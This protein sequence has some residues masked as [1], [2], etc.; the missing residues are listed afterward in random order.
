MM[1]FLQKLFKRKE[2]NSVTTNK[3]VSMT[4]STPNKPVSK[5]TPTPINRVNPNEEF[6]REEKAAM[7]TADFSEAVQLLHILYKNKMSSP[8]GISLNYLEGKKDACF[9]IKQFI[10]ESDG[11]SLNDLAPF[12]RSMDHSQNYIHED[13][14]RAKLEVL[15]WAYERIKSM[16][17]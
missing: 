13:F 10:N 2:V 9:Y 3:T 17:Y 12:Q 6:Y 7:G 15:R 16:G 14:H 11:Y 8:C 5:T 4:A 1:N